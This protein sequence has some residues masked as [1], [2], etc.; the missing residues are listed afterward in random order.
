VLLYFKYQ[1]QFASAN[2]RS[3][4]TDVRKFDYDSDG[5]PY[6]PLPARIPCDCGDPDC[7]LEEEF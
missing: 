1:S 6:R 2:D 5:Q 4:R 7:G 3:L